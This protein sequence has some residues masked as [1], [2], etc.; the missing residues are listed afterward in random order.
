M[1]C[2][3]HV[4][5]DQEGIPDDSQKSQNGELQG[6]AGQN[7]IL[8]MQ[9][10]PENGRDS[11]VCLTWMQGMVPPV[12]STSSVGGMQEV[13]V[14]ATFTEL[15][16][17]MNQVSLLHQVE[18]LIHILSPVT[19]SS[20]RLACGGR[21]PQEQSIVRLDRGTFTNFTAWERFMQKLYYN[22]ND[23][24]RI[25]LPSSPTALNDK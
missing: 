12:S 1:N 20:R 2:R 23:R 17:R 14:R 19:H 25:S 13:D 6:A 8:K 3:Q 21:V 18:G 9:N 11:L 24:N 22:S 5:L 10:G 15:F 16:S 4:S 7:R